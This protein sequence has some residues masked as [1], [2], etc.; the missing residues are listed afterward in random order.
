MRLGKWDANVRQGK[1]N[2]GYGT[3]DANQGDLGEHKFR[4]TQV[5]Y[6]Y[7]SEQYWPYIILFQVAI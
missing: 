3:W 5:S 1:W 2:A 6:Q 7:G 4:D